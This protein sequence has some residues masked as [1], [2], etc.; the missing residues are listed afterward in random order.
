MS[1]PGD[2]LLRVERLTKSFALQPNACRMR[3]Q[4]RPQAAAAGAVNGVSF[5]VRRGETLGIV[6]E[7]G[8][9]KSTLARCLVRLHEPDSGTLTL[10][11]AGRA[12]AHRAPTRRAYNRRVQMIF[13]DPYSSLN[14]R[15]TVRQCLAEALA[16]HRVV[17]AQEID[18]RVDRL[19]DLV[20][21]PREA[22][23]RYPHEFSGGQR[24]RIGIA[25]ALA[26]E[27]EIIIA[28]EPVSAL[29]V[30]VQAQIVNL[31]LELQNELGLALIFIT[32]DLR[33]VHH[34]AHRIAVM[35]LGRIME[36]GPTEEIFASPRHPYTRALL[37]AVP[38]L[39]PGRRSRRDAVQRRVAEPARAAARLPVPPALPAWRS[40]S[41]ASTSRARTA[42]RRLARRLPLRRPS[43]PVDPPRAGSPSSMSLKALEDRIGAVNDVLC[44]LSLL[45]WDS[46]TM[47]PAAATATRGAQIATLTR[48]ARDLL[49][50]ADMQRA[51]EGARRETQ[52]RDPDDPERRAVE[53]TDVAIAFHKRIPADLLQ[54][55]AA[56]RATANAAWIEAREKSDFSLFEPHLKRTVDLAREY[57]DAAGFEDHP[58]D[59]LVA[60][61]EPGETYANLKSLFGA[62]RPGLRTILEEALGRPRPRTDFLRRDFPEDGQRDIALSIAR[63]FGYDFGRGRLD[64][65]VHP[66]EISFTR[67][68]VRITT[69]YRRNYLP[70]ALFGAMHEAGHGLY[71]QNVDP[72]YTRTALATDLI[73]LYAVGGASFGAHESQSRLWENHVGRSRG[74]WRLNFPALRE[75]FPEALS[76]VDAETFHAA[77]NAPAASLIRTEAD[78]LTYDFHIMLRVDLEAAL[79]SG[80]LAV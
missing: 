21:L 55:R 35:Y 57:A 12:R 51:V 68:D 39:V 30:S 13:Q 33:L 29:D 19:L 61:Y 76:D 9:G 5:D 78:E 45:V 75:T 63:S 64:T 8:C 40:R 17:P 16:V 47:M 43:R 72:A 56:Q 71:E 38:G 24:Q 73:G 65:T 80:A 67:E 52:G 59:A 46:R 74:F 28:D 15:L 49:L 32:H 7:S 20:H 54:R 18:A 4:R 37:A 48:L 26:V 11:G 22:A 36:I 23:D 60:V 3:L 70:P 10:R 42:R 25:R 69:R 50:D 62:L 41:A 14:P 2:V 77:V 53:Q 6:G 58:Y 1:T 31:L 34:I 44:A 27:P 66:F 79:I